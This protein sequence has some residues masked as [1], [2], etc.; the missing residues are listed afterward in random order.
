[1]LFLERAELKNRVVGTMEDQKEGQLL[2]LSQV[3]NELILSTLEKK[4]NRLSGEQEIENGVVVTMYVPVKVWK[5]T[6]H[7]F[8]N[9]IFFRNKDGMH[10]LGDVIT[11]KNGRIFI[12]GGN[13]FCMANQV[14]TQLRLGRGNSEILG[15]LATEMNEMCKELDEAKKDIKK[16]KAEYQ[17]K[18]ELSDSLMKK[19]RNEQ[20]LE[21][22]EA[23]Q[24]IAEQVQEL[25][26]KSEEL[27][28]AR[29]M[30]ESLKSSLHEK[31]LSIRQLN[32]AKEKLSTNSREKLHKLEGE[33][34]KLVSALDED[35]QQKLSASNLQCE[36]VKKILLVSEKKCVEAEQKAQA[37]KEL[38]IRDDVILK[39]EDRG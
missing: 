4:K 39:L 26:A 7:K 6:Q 17:I 28:E 35:L 33:N 34:R 5:L 25:N 12:R 9:L 23:K 32:S 1:M 29:N 19:S 20:L 22:Q 14:G 2:R 13:D 21:F 10:W 38:R 11:W 36:G 31:E 18:E 24:L 27:S 8:S 16:L 3:L 37:P 30:L 15:S